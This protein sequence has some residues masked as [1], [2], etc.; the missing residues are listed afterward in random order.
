M[1]LIETRCQTEVVDLHRFFVAWFCGQLPQTETAFARL[2]KVLAEGMVLISPAG[3]IQTRGQILLWI[4]QAYGSRAEM[5]P[6]FRIWIE[7]FRLRHHRDGLALATYIEWQEV[8]GQTN[9]RLSSAL[10]AEK[11][12]SPNGVVWLHVHETALASSL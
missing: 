4:S 12:D 1:S 8:A 2:S 9:A 3:T 10:F 6:P 5:S 7:D 11:P